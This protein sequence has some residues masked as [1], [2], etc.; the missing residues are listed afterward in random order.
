MLVEF[1]NI[2]SLLLFSFLLILVKYPF[3]TK[4][5]AKS[6]VQSKKNYESHSN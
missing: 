4:V 5:S 3:S 2:R 6:N 1:G